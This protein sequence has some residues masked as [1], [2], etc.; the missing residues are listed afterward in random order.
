MLKC[1]HD[2]RTFQ[3]KAHPAHTSH[4]HVSHLLAQN[5]TIGSPPLHDASLFSP[6]AA[7]LVIC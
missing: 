2:M 1:T 4:H 7:I 3:D 5:K 6:L